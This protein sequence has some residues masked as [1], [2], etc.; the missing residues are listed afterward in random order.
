MDAVDELNLKKNARR[1]SFNGG[2]TADSNKR[3]RF[4][5]E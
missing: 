1:H 2:K 4:P 3:T 5:N